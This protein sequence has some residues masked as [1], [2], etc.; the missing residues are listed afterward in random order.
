MTETSRGKTGPTLPPGS[1]E[2]ELG[3][4]IPGVILPPEPWTVSALRAWSAAGPVD[5]PALFGRHAPVVLD[6][7]CGNGRSV[8]GGA[9]ARPECDFL[10]VDNLPVVIRYA[11]KRAR[12]RGLAN[13]RFA[14]GDARDVIARRIAPGAL[15][16]L[17][18]YHPQPY[19]QP[20]HASRRLLTPL[21]LLQ[22]H[23]ALAPGGRL[24][25]QTDNPAYWKYM[26]EVVPA[27]FDFHEQAGP[28]PDAPEGRTRREILARQKHLPV[29][30]GVGTARTDIDPDQARQAAEALPPPAFNADRRLMALDRL[31][32]TGLHPRARRRR[33]RREKGPSQTP[34]QGDPE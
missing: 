14:V 26:L 34:D 23:R 6:L 10:G 24:V 18:V 32:R 3:V 12:Q 17:H 7:G 4:P 13:V 5:F 9:I 33:R 2:H 29:F 28:W 19:Y 11:R 22:A 25:L 31:E 27:F 15:A 16:E 1:I 20:G 30:R 21:F 8:L